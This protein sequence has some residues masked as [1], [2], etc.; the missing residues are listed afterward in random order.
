MLDQL[1]R[2]WYVLLRDIDWFLRQPLQIEL[3]ERSLLA[4]I[5]V[6][7]VSG[8]VGSLVVVR[9]MSFFGDALAHAVLPG[10]AYMYQRVRREN[11]PG[12]IARSEQDPLLWGGLAA[13]IVSA[14]AIGILTR[15]GRLRSDSAIGVVFAGMF[16]LG[17][18]MISRMEGFSQDLTHI[19]F[20]EL[21]GV[22]AADLELIIIFGVGVLLVVILLYK[23]FMLISFDPV[24]ART[25]RLPS[26]LLRYILLIL[27]AV[28]IVV[29]LQTVGVA[30]M[31][32]MLVT[33]AATASLLTHRLH[34][35]MMTAGAI[36]AVSSVI[37]FYVSY[38]IDIATG[39]AI[40]LAA[41][42]FFIIVF[43][44][45]T[46]TRYLSTTSLLFNERWAA[47]HSHTD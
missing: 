43:V 40:V 41:T 22:S 25:L 38:H 23:E 20:G 4:A 13:G 37:G 19:L 39:A 2:G 3:F 47:R 31:I 34:R 14:V 15:T 8:V 12:I 46:V 28:T 1:V 10:V 42:L 21:F 7:V 24:L 16:A 18:A 5:V 27:I 35:M 45:Q 36:G 33:P 6:G 30:L 9:G 17:I 44:Q 29:S 32:A 26:E 11:V